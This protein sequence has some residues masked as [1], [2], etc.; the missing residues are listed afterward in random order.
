VVTLCVLTAAFLVQP[1]D[2]AVPLTSGRSPDGGFEVVLEADFDSARYKTYEFKG[3]DEEF[4]GILVL[5]AYTR[6]AVGRIPWPGDASNTSLSPM[7]GRANVVWRGDSNAVAVNVRDPYYW[8]TTLFVKNRGRFVSVALPDFAEVAGR[9][10]PSPKLLRARGMEEA[11]RWTEEGNLVYYVALSA[12]QPVD[13]PLS[14]RAILGVSRAGCRVLS[15][16]PV[17]PDR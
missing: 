5:D 15:R 16:K 3:S 14:Y 2:A 4:P 1:S 7:R 13:Q 11:E 6:R 12:M 8:F 17:D 9:P 10:G